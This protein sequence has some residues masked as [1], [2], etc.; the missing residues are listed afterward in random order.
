[1]EKK[2]TDIQTTDKGQRDNT[3]LPNF[4]SSCQSVLCLLRLL[5]LST[6]G[7]WE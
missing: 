6:T 3:S 7:G 2:K 1:M 5:I 4:L